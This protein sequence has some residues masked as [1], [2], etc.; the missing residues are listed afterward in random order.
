MKSFIHYPKWPYTIVQGSGRRTA[1]GRNPA[2]FKNSTKPDEDQ[3]LR[4]PGVFPKRERYFPRL[5]FK[6]RQ[7]GSLGTDRM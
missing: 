7:I 1:T 6:S 4:C 3:W 5:M 2:A